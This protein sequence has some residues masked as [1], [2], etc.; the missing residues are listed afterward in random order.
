MS[1]HLLQ[2]AAGMMREQAEAYRRIDSVCCQL[3]AALVVGELAQ[4]ES[5]TRAGE[6]ELLRMRSRLVQI[7]L[8]LVAF[9]E[10]RTAASQ[11]PDRAAR[12]TFDAASKKLFEAAREF[13][14]TQR[15][16]EVLARGGSTF[17]AACIEH[18]GVP[19]TTYRAPYARRVETQA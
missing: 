13:T 17:A 11:P 3:T 16:A 7:T 5:L 4:I 10:A 18:C 2:T 19:P 12:D 9:S 14:Q 1:D 8:S 15:R 6:S